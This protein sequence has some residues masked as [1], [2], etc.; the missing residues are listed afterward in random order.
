MNALTVEIVLRRL[1][2]PGSNQFIVDLDEG[3]EIVV[4]RKG[5]PLKIFRENAPDLTV[6]ENSQTYLDGGVALGAVANNFSPYPWGNPTAYFCNASTRSLF[7]FDEQ[8]EKV[9]SGEIHPKLRRT[10]IVDVDACDDPYG[11]MQ[12]RRT[13]FIDE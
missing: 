12:R 3:F 8:V 9:L 11:P 4:N 13:M 2:D 10:G 6:A 7:A 5:S 1:P